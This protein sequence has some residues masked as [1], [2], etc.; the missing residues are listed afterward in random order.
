MTTP[1][2]GAL[3]RLERRIAVR[4]RIREGGDR[5]VGS[6]PAIIQII[7]AVVIA[8]SITRWLLGHPYPLLAVT[9]T[10][11]SLGLTRD[12]RPRR[13]AE[14]L[15]G[16]VLGVAVSESIA[17]L[18]GSGVWQLAIVLL[19]VFVVGRFISPNPQF[20]V[21]SAI[22]SAIVMLLP[23]GQGLFGRTV[24]A[25]IAGVVALLVTALIPRDPGRT[26]ARDRQAIFA[27]LTESTES[28]AR[29]LRDA[30]EAA[31]ELALSRLRRAAP[32]FEA[33]KQ[34]L[35]TAIAVAR[36]S[37]FLRGRLPELRR[38]SRAVDAVDFATRHLRMI[39][40]R[41]LYL[42][43]DGIPRPGLADAL[44]TVATG[45]RMLGEELQEPQAAGAA[46]SV[47]TDLARRLD[48]VTLMPDAG[49]ADASVLLLL[50]P[51]VVDLLVGTGM[52]HDEARDLL[53]P[54]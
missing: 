27:V 44:T 23:A 49:L 19:V 50:R 32:L 35:D 30:D 41:C 39:A 31:G 5:V 21:A 8:Y 24:D 22:P 36:I 40:R 52:P 51:L 11:T 53:P 28:I 15:L 33:W 7:V 10:I 20:A 6:L 47:L 13:V 9:V 12:A 18:V 38:N 4:A 43:R 3:R 29:S 37:P 54:I 42:G 26:A 2:D 25:I 46:R 16:I 14:S 48:P 1:D 34:S 45:V 17:L